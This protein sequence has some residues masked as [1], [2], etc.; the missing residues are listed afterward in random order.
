MAS[1]FYYAFFFK[2]NGCYLALQD[3]QA[4]QNNKW[5]A[6]YSGINECKT[7]PNIKY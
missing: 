5:F 7:L 4:L 2:N 3:T 1:A 6:N